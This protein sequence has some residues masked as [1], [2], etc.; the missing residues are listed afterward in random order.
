MLTWLFKPISKDECLNI[1]QHEVDLLKHVAQEK[2]T[3]SAMQKCL[4]GWPKKFKA[5]LQANDKIKQESYEEQAKERSHVHKRTTYINWFQQD[6]RPPIMAAI[7]KYHG[8]KIDALH[9]LKIAYKKLGCFSPYKKLGRSSLYGWFT[10]RGEVKAK[11]AHFR[12]TSSNHKAKFT[13]L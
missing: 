5:T 6:S 7:K 8:N 10:D 12:H 11:Y 13:S 1:L 2:D 9:F 4:V 3:H